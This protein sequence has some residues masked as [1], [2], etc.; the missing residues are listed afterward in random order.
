MG[1]INSYR[2]RGVGVDRGGVSQRPKWRPADIVN[3][4]WPLSACVSSNLNTIAFRDYGLMILNI[5]LPMLPVL[6]LSL[7][8]KWGCQVLVTFFPALS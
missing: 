3:I 1:L 8:H 6:V 5:L 4:R 2:L 7:I